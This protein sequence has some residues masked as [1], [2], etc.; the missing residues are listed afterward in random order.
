MAVFGGLR[1]SLDNLTGMARNDKANVLLSLAD[2]TADTADHGRPSSDV[3]MERVN[4]L[5]T[6]ISQGHYFVSSGDLALK[7]IDSMREG[8]A[9]RFRNDS[10]TSH[11]SS[12]WSDLP[13]HGFT[14]ATFPP[15]RA[16]DSAEE[17]NDERVGKGDCIRRT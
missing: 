2:I 12:S 13:H 7:L 8:P 16:S 15:P 11:G 4:S 10:G 3:R 6:A 1:A 9:L 14:H 17:V 5:R